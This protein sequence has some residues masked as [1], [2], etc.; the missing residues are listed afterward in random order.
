MLMLEPALLLKV[1]QRVRTVVLW[2]FL[3]IVSRAM[4]LMLEPVWISK[5]VQRRL[6]VL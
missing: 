2:M 6:K 5:V 4:L 3:L 1:E